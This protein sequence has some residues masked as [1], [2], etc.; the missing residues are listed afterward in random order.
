MYIHVMKLF[1]VQIRYT[2]SEIIVSQKLLPPFYKAIPSAMKR[3]SYKKG[4]L[5]GRKQFRSILVYQ[6]K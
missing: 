5:S 6:S 1:Q 2:Q 4:V 3:W